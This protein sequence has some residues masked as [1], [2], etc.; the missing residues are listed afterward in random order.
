MC[1]CP[2]SAKSHK[3]EGISVAGKAGEL[4][5]PRLRRYGGDILVR[6]VLRVWSLQKD[7]REMEEELGR[8]L[9]TGIREGHGGRGGFV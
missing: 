5:T 6:L 4:S 9:G 7:P 2:D 3:P 8:V 1:S